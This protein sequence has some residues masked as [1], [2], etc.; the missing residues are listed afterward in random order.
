MGGGSMLLNIIIVED[1]EEL[2]EGWQDI[3]TLDGHRVHCFLNGRNALE[4]RALIMQADVLVT[5]YYLPDINGLTLVSTVRKVR[6]DLPI[7]LLTGTRD[8]AIRESLSQV[9]NAMFLSK[10]I[11]IEQLERSIRELIAASSKAPAADADKAAASKAPAA[12]A[13]KVDRTPSS[14]Y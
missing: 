3:L 5:D 4:N 1:S 7:I 2:C 13:D 11:R 14:P 9:E 8:P 12:D 6:A 10:P